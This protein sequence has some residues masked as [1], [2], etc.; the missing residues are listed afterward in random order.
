MLF[1]PGRWYCLLK[2]CPRL[3]PDRDMNAQLASQFWI[4]RIAQ[5][6][7]DESLLTPQPIQRSMGSLF[8]G[9]V[10]EVAERSFTRCESIGEISIGLLP[11]WIRKIRSQ[12]CES[13]VSVKD[14]AELS[15]D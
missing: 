2:L 6:L 14:A 13:G 1:K 8:V 15:V 11:L 10:K 5:H 3:V 12:L 4:T 9:T 7:G